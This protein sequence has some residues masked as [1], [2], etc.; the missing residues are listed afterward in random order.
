M[1]SQARAGKRVYQME[2]KGMAKL[3]WAL[4]PLGVLLI[5]IFR[6]AKSGILLGIVLALVGFFLIPL[7]GKPGW[8]LM[9]VGVFLGYWFHGSVVVL[10]LGVIPVFIGLLLVLGAN[11]AKPKSKDVHDSKD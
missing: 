3:G 9:A 5:V 11:L 2:L 8:T 6:E 4:I 7:K 10:F 1:E